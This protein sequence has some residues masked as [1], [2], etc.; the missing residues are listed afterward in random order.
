MVA[1]DVD[2]VKHSRRERLFELIA[3]FTY[4]WETWFTSDG[5]VEWINPAVERI[6]GFTVRQCLD[7][8]DYPIQLLAPHESPRIRELLQAASHGS[9]GNDVEF[10]VARKDGAQRWVAVS[11]Q[12]LLDGD[13]HQLGFR[14]SMR[15]I[16]ERKRAE[17]ALQKAVAAAREANRAKSQFLAAVSHDLRQPLQAISMFLGSLSAG[18]IS[19]TGRNIIDDIKLCLEGCNEILDDLAEISKLE[20]GIVSAEAT[21]FPLVDILDVMETGF[22]SLAEEKGVRLRVVA[23]SLYVHADYSLLLRIV[24]NL[25]SNAV[26]HGKGGKILIGARRRGSDVELQ[27]WD[28]GPGIPE[29]KQGAIFEDFCQ[30]GNPARDRKFGLG[31]GLAIVRR[32][33]ELMGLTYGVRSRPGSGAMFWVRIPQ[34]DST[35]SQTANLRETGNDIAGLG[36]LVV[37]DETQQ[38]NA[39]TRLLEAH[40]ARVTPVERPGDM[41]S[42]LARPFKLDV[43]IVDYRLGGGHT[44]SDAIREA[45]AIVNRTL[46]AIILT[47]DTDVSRVSEAAAAGHLLLHK[48]VNPDRL[49]AAIS[50]LAKAE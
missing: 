20:A 16:T 9:S 44:G 47:G 49:L 40:G 21:A 15:D 50:V 29:D 39:L 4:D 37:E 28:N 11:W 41:R 25:A 34:S 36:I 6:T 12:P 18:D 26:R 24:Q 14:T 35:A 45:E 30:L 1:S 2:R 22:T 19:T 38:R 27:V 43:M 31:L 13:S 32:H 46:P 42:A 8:A 10:E 7:M 17:L 48:P 5:R 23:S 3:N 33:A